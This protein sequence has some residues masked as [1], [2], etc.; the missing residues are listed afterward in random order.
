MSY[1]AGIGRL[2]EESGPSGACT[3]IVLHSS[4]LIRHQC[5]SISCWWRHTCTFLAPLYCLEQPCLN[6]NEA[7]FIHRGS[8]CAICWV[9]HT[10][11]L[12][13]CH[14]AVCLESDK[15]LQGVTQAVLW[16]YSQ[17]RGTQLMLT[18]TAEWGSFTTHPL[19]RC[20]YSSSS[21]RDISLFH[22]VAFASSCPAWN[23]TVLRGGIH[24]LRDI[25]SQI[26][27]E[28]IIMIYNMVG[29]NIASFYPSIYS[30]VSKFIEA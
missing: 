9:K 25:D 2:S 27:L 24:K 10:G 12:L 21:S 23:L 30:F 15:S 19:S 6:K 16:H 14:D 17:Q 3:P 8:H 7:S 11:P 29:R 5:G 20:Q 13:K 28:W 22:R 1:W 4:S 26:L 18:N